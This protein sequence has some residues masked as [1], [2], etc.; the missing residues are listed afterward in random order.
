MEISCKLV[1]A[2]IVE[3]HGGHIS[4]DEDVNEKTPLLSDANTEVEKDERKM[5]IW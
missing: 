3:S 4:M 1:K 2:D 5:T